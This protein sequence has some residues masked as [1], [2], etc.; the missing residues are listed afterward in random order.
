[1]SKPKTSPAGRAASD[2]SPPSVR[3]PQCGLTL[4]PAAAG[5]DQ[6]IVVAA[7]CPRCGTRLVLGDASSQTPGA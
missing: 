1:M 2:Q 5:H 4:H 7:S 6:A 3:C